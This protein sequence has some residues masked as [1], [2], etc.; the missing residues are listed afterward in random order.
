MADGAVE[1]AVRGILRLEGAALLGL[2]LLGYGLSGGGWGMFALLILVPDLVILAYLA[3]PRPGAVAYNAAHAT[4]GPALLL[5]A[6]LAWP[7]AAGWAV[8]LALIWFAHIGADR[9]LGYGLKYPGGFWMTH[10]GRIGRPGRQG[11]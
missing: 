4:P 1:G 10:L 5:A 2:A 9:A 11:S 7:G 6:G 3:G 8:P